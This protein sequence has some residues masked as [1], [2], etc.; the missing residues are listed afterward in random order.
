L[1]QERENGDA[2]GSVRGLYGIA[3]VGDG[4]QETGVQIQL[5][6]ADCKSAISVSLAKPEVI[7]QKQGL[8]SKQ[9]A[10]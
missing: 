6:R 4:I 3:V 5:Q 8:A 9:L 2:S 10:W 7:A 1:L